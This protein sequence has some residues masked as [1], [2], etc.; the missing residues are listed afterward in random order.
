[1]ESK[2]TFEFTDKAPQLNVQEAE[3][4]RLLGFPKD[5]ALTERSRELA[6]WARNWY[7]EHGRPWIY[8]RSAGGVG[9]EADKIHLSGAEFSSERLQSQFAAAQAHDAVLVAVSAG[10]ECEEKARQCWQEGKPDEYF[11]LE[12]YGSAVVE[13]LVTHAAGN[14]CARAEQ[15]GMAALPH[16]SPGY[17]G[18]PVSDQPKLWSIIRGNNGTPFPADLD[19][20]ETGM[21]RPKKSLLT[22]FGLTRHPEKVAPGSKLVPCENCSLPNC[23]Y[24]RAPYCDFMPQAETVGRLVLDALETIETKTAT[25]PVLD[26][27]ARYSVNA[28]ALRKWSEERLQLE[29]ASDGFITARFRYEGTTCSNFGRP[30]QYDYQVRLTPR[31]QGY[32]ITEAHSTPADGDTGHAQ[33]CEFLKDP[34]GFMSRLTAEKPLLGRPLNDVLTWKRPVNPAGCFCEAGSRE[35]KWGMI[36][37]V[38]HFALAQ[39]G[40]A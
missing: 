27:L 17:T 3:Y 35:H 5:H 20:M 16:Y 38:I 31:A 23:N 25:A 19:V 4:L 32:R 21:L 22:V 12:M 13:H 34:D 10:K 15:N 24:R 6:T 7:A 9:I 11:F 1:M 39:K 8:A 26:K 33:Q 30:I 28:R 40:S 2:P 18:W 36:F 14:I 37:E 29:V